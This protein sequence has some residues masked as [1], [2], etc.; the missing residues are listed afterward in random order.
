MNKKLITEKVYKNLYTSNI[1][2]FWNK[3]TQ[4]NKEMKLEN[5]ILL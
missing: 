2:I 1:I 3:H 4:Q 5:F